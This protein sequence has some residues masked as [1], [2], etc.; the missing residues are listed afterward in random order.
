MNGVQ[1]ICSSETFTTRCRAGELV[2]ME[3]AVYGR[4]RIGPCVKKDMG[5][6]GCHMDVL[7]IG[8]F[9]MILFIYYENFTK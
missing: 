1:E 3:T 9:T 2:V 6:L 4:M 7:D 8:I 5:Q